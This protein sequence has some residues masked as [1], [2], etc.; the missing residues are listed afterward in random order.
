MI[1]RDYYEWFVETLKLAEK[2]SSVQWLVK[3]HPSSS[4]YNEEG[5]VSALLSGDNIKLVPEDIKTNALMKVAD[6]VLTVRGTAGLECVLYDAK[7]ILAGAAYYMDLGFTENCRTIEQ[8][9]NT[10]RN[11]QKKGLISDDLKELVKKVIYWRMKSWFFYSGIFGPER[12]AD[13]PYE[14]ITRHELN[15]YNHTLT[16]LNKRR[17][18]D[19]IY[20]KKLIKFFSEKKPTLCAL[21]YLHPDLVE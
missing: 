17:L 18:K 21:D 9:A 4:L 14:S 11:I 8:Y 5:V 7:P 3:P 20:Y 12:V 15:N 2:I 10:L 16:F 6:A 1:Y 13:L 19:D